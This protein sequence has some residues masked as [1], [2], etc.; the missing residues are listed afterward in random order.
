MNDS[1]LARSPFAA[2]LRASYSVVCTYVVRSAVSYEVCV[3][4]S[5]A[6]KHRAIKPSFRVE[7]V[8]VVETRDFRGD[9]IA[10]V[11]IALPLDG[12]LGDGL[13]DGRGMLN[14]HFLRALVLLV[15]ADA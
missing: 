11:R 4:K 12:P 7:I 8:G 14:L 15:A 6:T 10:E 13:D 3:T 9:E 5:V 2:G 1:K